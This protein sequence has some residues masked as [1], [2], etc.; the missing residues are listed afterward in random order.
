MDLPDIF[1]G[2]KLL[3][4]RKVRQFVYKFQVFSLFSQHNN[5]TSNTTRSYFN[6]LEHEI[7]GTAQKYTAQRHKS[8]WAIFFRNRQSMTLNASVSEH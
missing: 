1:F 7:K 6:L 5:I 4:G 8:C 3:C 2:I